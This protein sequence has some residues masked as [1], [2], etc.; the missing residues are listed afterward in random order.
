MYFSF[1]TFEV[2]HGSSSSVLSLL[3]LAPS[4]HRLAEPTSRRLHSGLANRLP[5]L[6]CHVAAAI[7]E[8]EAATSNSATFHHVN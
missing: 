7:G 1:V 8:L 3:P 4:A 2:G 5:P 6:N